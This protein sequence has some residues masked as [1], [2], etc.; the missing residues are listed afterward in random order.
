M[1]DPGPLDP[2]RHIELREITV[3]EADAQHAH[4]LLDEVVVMLA[5]SLRLQG[6]FAKARGRGPGYRVV[7]VGAGAH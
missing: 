6:E 7:H 3:D 4:D 5:C 2:D 1:D